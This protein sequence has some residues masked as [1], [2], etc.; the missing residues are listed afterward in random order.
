M[1]VSSAQCVSFST[2][3]HAVHRCGTVCQ[4]GVRIYMSWLWR[5]TGFG[6]HR[7]S[8]ETLTGRTA[9]GATLVS[10]LTRGRAGEGCGTPH[11]LF[12]NLHHRQ[13]HGSRFDAA[14]CWTPVCST[15]ISRSTARVTLDVL[16]T[17]QHL[18]HLCWD[19]ACAL[20]TTICSGI[21]QRVPVFT[22]EHTLYG[23]GTSQDFSWRGGRGL[24]RRCYTCTCLASVTSG[25]AQ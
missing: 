11:G 9:V 25:C 3:C 15:L 7:Y 17:G 22:V 8:D 14:T 5:R 16:G 21:A 10:E 13:S 1:S 20:R 19:Y 12:D 24:R 23:V 4:D 6:N 2:C 18:Y